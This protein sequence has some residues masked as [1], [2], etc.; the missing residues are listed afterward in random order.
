MIM[1][2]V[3]IEVL[4]LSRLQ[5]VLSTRRRALEPKKCVITFIFSSFWT[6]FSKQCWSVYQMFPGCV[7]VLY[8]T[9]TLS[10]GLCIRCVNTERY[11]VHLHT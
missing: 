3:S 2:M 5:F 9:A 4:W 1:I 6:P 8:L 7:V 10:I 11:L